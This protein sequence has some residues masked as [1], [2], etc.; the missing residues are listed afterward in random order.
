M[1][2]GRLNLSNR[3]KKNTVDFMIEF[4]TL[5]MKVDTDE[6]HMQ[7]YLS[8]NNIPA[9]KL[10]PNHTSPPSMAATFLATHLMVVLQPSEYSVFHGR[11]TPIQL[12]LP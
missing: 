3:E 9:V 4:D 11:D 1:P 7:V 8:G 10:P 12:G 5:A 6:C 2:N